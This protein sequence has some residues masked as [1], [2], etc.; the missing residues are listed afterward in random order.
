VTNTNSA[1]AIQDRVLDIQL[2]E[3]LAQFDPRH[4]VE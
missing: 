2:H 3:G 4:R 1:G